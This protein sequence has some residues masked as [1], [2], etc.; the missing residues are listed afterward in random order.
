MTQKSVM[1]ALNTAWNLVNFRAGLIRALNERGYEVVAVAPQ[2]GYAR[3]LEQMGCR[4]LPLPIDSQ[5]A[6]PGRDF[7][8]CFRFWRLMRRERPVVFL[9]YTV[10]P[11]VFGSL[12]AHSLGIPVVNNIA[13]LGAV[14]IRNGWLAWVVRLLYRLALARSRRVFFQNGDDLQLFEKAGLVSSKQADCLPG[15]G[16]DLKRFALTPLAPLAGRKFRFVLIARMLWDKGVG[17]YVEAARLVRKRFADVEF[18]LLGFLDVQNPAAIARRQME[19]WV[20][21]GVV[22]YLGATEDV[23]LVV[24]SSDCV[25][26]PSYR[27]GVPRALL[28]AAALGR[29]IITTDVVGCREVVDEGVNGFLCK[30]RDAEDLARKMIKMTGLSA[31]ARVEM[32]S[33]GRRKVE[34]KFDERIVIDRYLQ[35]IGEIAKQTC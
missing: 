22:S 5:G 13:G 14:F 4:F 12:A 34:S 10:K 7:V 19:A 6:H 30:P 31:E 24:A 16:I 29:P 28:E 32:G 23:R 33:M 20:D 21:E 1:I 11:N 9:G 2:D 25:V 27:E 35:V 3:Y 17:E 8:L 26:L 15:S 18:C